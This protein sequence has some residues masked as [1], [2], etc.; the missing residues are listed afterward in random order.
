MEGYVGVVSEYVKHG[1]EVNIEEEWAED[2]A[3]GDTVGYRAG[4]ERECINLRK[5]G[6]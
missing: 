6:W 2:R 4:G 5:S 1:E 3:M